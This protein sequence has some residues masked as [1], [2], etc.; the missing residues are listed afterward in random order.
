M[1][2][3]LSVFVQ[4]N[5][6]AGKSSPSV[7]QDWIRVTGVEKINSASGFISR[8]IVYAECMREYLRATI[9]RTVPIFRNY[10][11]I[12]IDG[13]VVVDVA[14]NVTVDD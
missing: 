5:A 11:E 9:E 12:D 2:R 3:F 6:S 10:V 14:E 8:M 13:F 1:A 4:Y 7:V